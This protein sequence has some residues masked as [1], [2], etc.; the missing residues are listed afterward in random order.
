MDYANTY[1][2]VY[3]WFYASDMQLNMDTDAD[4]LVLPKACSKIA[5]YF[6]FLNDPAGNKTIML[7]TV[8]S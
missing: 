8:L 4:F 5:W 2:N 3:A 6:R 7:I 1:K